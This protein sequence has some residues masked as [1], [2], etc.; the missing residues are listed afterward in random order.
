MRK[1]ELIR[2]LGRRLS[3]AKSA[4]KRELTASLAAKTREELR[5]LAKENKIA[6]WH[7]LRKCEI[8]DALVRVMSD[9]NTRSGNGKDRPAAVPSPAPAAARRTNGNGSSIQDHV[10]C[11]KYDV[12]HAEVTERRLQR[13]LPGGYAKDRIVAMVRDPYWLHVYWELTRQSIERTEATLGQQ[14]YSAKPILRL[15][16]VDSS[17]APGVSES[18]IRDIPIHGGVNNWYIDVD[19]PPHSYRVDIGFLSAKG[20]FITLARSNVVRTPEAG[21]SDQLDE[22]WLSVK[23]DSE[24]V[25]AMSG[26]HDPNAGNEELK[27][28]F[29][30][31]LRRPHVARLPEQLWLG[32]VG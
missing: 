12:G 17:E 28:L 1:A 30:E 29:E 15:M 11:S 27:K 10:E 16:G 31:R 9:S 13:K 3:V 18:V 26:G 24:R 22:H 2:A 14:W 20:R 21:M 4:R 19:D 23:R 6:G 8:V 7:T 5:L 32:R 25:F